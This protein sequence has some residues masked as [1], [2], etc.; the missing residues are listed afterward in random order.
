ME[1]KNKRK[2]LEKVRGSLNFPDKYYVDPIGI[3]G[4]LA[5]WWVDGV[6]LDVRF[7]SKNIFRCI[8][9][10]PGRGH[11]AASFIYAPPCRRERRV[12]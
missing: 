12:F 1:T 5:L 11:W 3:S 4:G 2:L 9:S 10:A 8:I 6:G 7:K